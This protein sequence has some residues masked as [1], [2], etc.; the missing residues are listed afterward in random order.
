M[1]KFENRLSAYFIT[2]IG[3][4]CW[5][6]W[7]AVDSSYEQLAR[8]VTATD[9]IRYLPFIAPMFF[10]YG[11]GCVFLVAVPIECS[12]IAYRALMGE[13]KQRE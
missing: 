6:L 1:H 13:R 9:W 2:A 3:F 5:L 10:A 11:S 4:S 12:I 7:W 8:E